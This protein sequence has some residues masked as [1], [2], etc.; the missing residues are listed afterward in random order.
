MKK[1]LLFSALLFC[2]IGQPLLAYTA[3]D[4]VPSNEIRPGDLV[5]F[6]ISEKGRHVG[7]YLEDGLFF[8]ASRSEGVTLS[9]L[10][11]DYWRYRL[12]SVR[13]VNHDISHA[14]LKRA[15]NKY[16]GAPYRYGSEGPHRFD[17]SGLVWRIFG[18]HG[19]DLP[20]T[21][22]VQLRTGTKILS[23]RDYLIRNRR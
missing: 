10:D 22:K 15:F 12:I 19:V 9:R 1:A 17:C 13:R 7:V 18:E 23:G 4:P 14:A 8:H 2:F 11:D 5:F 20:R 3:P 21:T 16:D 6:W